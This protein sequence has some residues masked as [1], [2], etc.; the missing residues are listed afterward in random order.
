MNR[1]AAVLLAAL[2]GLSSGVQAQDQSAAPPAEQRLSADQYLAAF[3]SMAGDQCQKARGV[4][5]AKA[6]KE[7]KPDVAVALRRAD[8][9]LCDCIPPRIATLRAHLPPGGKTDLLD[10]QQFQARYFPQFIGPCAAQTLRETYTQDCPVQFA[11]QR[12]NTA[13]YCACMA[14]GVSGMSN[15]DLFAAAAENADYTPRAAEA[16]QRKLPP[17][18]PPPHVKQL[19]DLDKQCAAK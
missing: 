16:R 2:L 8:T 10:Q 3:S 1:L 11:K 5:A 7:G 17:P 12:P 15:D 6:E 19:M 14:Q 4:A 9:M 13:A 18:E